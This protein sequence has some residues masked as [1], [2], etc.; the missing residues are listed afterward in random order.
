MVRRWLIDIFIRFSE[1]HLYNTPVRKVLDNEKMMNFY[2]TLWTLPG[3]QQYI[4]ERESRFVHSLAAKQSDE[5][6]GQRFENSIL[7][8]KCRHAAE[9][10][11]A[12]K[13]SLAQGYKKLVASG[14]R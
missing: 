14:K 13:T 1:K 5:V 9:L 12:S 3:F 7:Y 2:A 4:I 11:K 8:F 6:R 10:E